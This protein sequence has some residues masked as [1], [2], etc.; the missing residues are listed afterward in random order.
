MVAHGDAIYSLC[1]RT[2]RDPDLAEDVLQQ[3]FLE[4]HRDLATFQARAAPRTWLF[5]IAIHRCQDAIRKRRRR[6]ARE[7]PGD[8]GVVALPD[9]ADGPSAFLEKQQRFAA[10]ESCLERL[11]EDASMAVQLRFLI[12]M[13]FEEMA[14]QL[15]AKADTLQTRVMRAMPV[16]RRCMTRKGWTGE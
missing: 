5:G 2:L 14:K 16:L 13:T 3:T 10:L 9:P 8:D 4:A 12:G 15:G 7:E 1:V 11:S 6:D